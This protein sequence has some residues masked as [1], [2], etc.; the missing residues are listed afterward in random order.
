MGFFILFTIKLLILFVLNLFNSYIYN[1]R[2]EIIYL[3]LF[4]ENNCLIN[5]LIE[6][7]EPKVIT[8]LYYIVLVM[9]Y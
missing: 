4:M 2:E 8:P 7:I 3:L 9:E 6:S 1:I 5:I